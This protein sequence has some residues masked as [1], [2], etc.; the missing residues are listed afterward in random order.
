MSKEEKS[1]ESQIGNLGGD[2]NDSMVG[3]KI[4]V[5]GARQDLSDEESSEFEQFLQR[6]RSNSRIVPTDDTPNEEDAPPAVINVRDGWNPIPRAAL[7]E[8]AKFYPEDWQF[9]VKSATVEAIKNWSAID[10]EQA[11]SVNSTLD[12]IIRSCVSIKTSAGN[13]PWNR[14]NS[15]DRFWFILKVREYTFHNG[16]SK[17]SYED[18]CS[19]CNEK[20]TFN[21]DCDSL[22]YEFPSEDIMHQWNALERCWYINPKDYD[23]DH[24]T[25]KLYVPTLE[26]DAAILDFAFMKAREARANK[27]KNLPKVLNPVFLKY[28]PWLLPKAPKDEKV[29]EKFVNDCKAQYD[30]W[31]QSMFDFM[32]DVIANVNILPSEKMRKICPH[33]GEEVVSNVQFPHGQVKYLFKTKTTHRKFGSRGE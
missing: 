23:V 4:K 31:D 14:M 22:Y 15:W 1:F 13:V 18:E 6:S 32:E 16:E 20:I 11:D 26:K 7:G 29:F 24:P 10:E 27:Q 8:R 25:V 3:K 19:E 21:L 33:C 12:E 9:Y 5:P 30:S 28:L 2:P 17:I